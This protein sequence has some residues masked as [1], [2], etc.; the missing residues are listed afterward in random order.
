MA[1]ACVESQNEQQ[2]IS[3]NAAFQGGRGG[4]G[5][6]VVAALMVVV[7]V[8]AVATTAVVDARCLAK[9]VAR[10]VI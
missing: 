9:F 10:H 8:V 3:V 7:F 2:Q 1:K 6:F 5:G 4:R